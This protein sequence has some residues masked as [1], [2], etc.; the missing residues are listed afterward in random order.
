[1][2]SLKQFK[3][4]TRHAKSVINAYVDD[5]DDAKLFNSISDDINTQKTVMSKQVRR[6]QY[7]GVL[8]AIGF[9][10]E[11]MK[12][13]EATGEEKQQYATKMRDSLSSHRESVLGYD[14]LIALGSIS[15]L[16]YLL[17]TSGRRINEVLDGEVKFD[18]DTETVYVKLSKSQTG[19][20]VPIYTLIN[21]TEWKRIYYEMVDEYKTTKPTT[22]GCYLNLKIRNIVGDKSMK[23]SS[24]IL[25]AIYARYI[26]EFRN[27]KHLTLSGVITKYLN[28]ENSAS[29]QYYQ[30]VKF[31]KTVY[32]YLSSNRL[33][34]LMVH[35]L[36][37]QTIAKL[38][39]TAK[40]RG[41]KPKDATKAELI[42]M[43]VKN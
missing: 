2:E 5:A 43:L 17:L 13:I 30:H 22:V 9:T 6:S 4:L 31:D 41:L 27:D 28:H 11:T 25:R 19:D 1:M 16:S 18:D 21:F 42:E 33:K 38:T 8:R 35:E 34:N 32:D 37:Q 36:K 15:N 29:S 10:D 39:A 20:M 14:D 12:P 26:Y 3:K 23:M 40:K 24:H 7:R